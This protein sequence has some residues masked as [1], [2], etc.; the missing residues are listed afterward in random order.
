MTFGHAGYFWRHGRRDEL[1][2]YRRHIAKPS[3]ALWILI[4]AGD[5]LLILSGVGMLALIALVSVVAV[6]AFGGYLLTRRS[7]AAN[8]AISAAVPVATRPAQRRVSA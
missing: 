3:V 4:A 7:A 2:S 6:V 5:L 8:E 1:M